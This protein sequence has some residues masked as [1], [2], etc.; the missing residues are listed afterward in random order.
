MRYESHKI[1]FVRNHT[2]CTVV[3]MVGEWNSIY[4]FRDELV[5]KVIVL[6]LADKYIFG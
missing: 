4:Y 1:C 3:S 2:D 5:A 6:S